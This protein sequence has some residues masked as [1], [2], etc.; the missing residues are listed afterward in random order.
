VTGGDP[1]RTWSLS[2]PAVFLRAACVGRWEL[3]DPAG[4][5]ETPDA[6]AER[7]AAAQRLCTRCTCLTPCRELTA[8]IPAS[9]RAGVWAGQVHTPDRTTTSTHRPMRTPQ[10]THRG[11]HPMPTPYIPRRRELDYPRLDARDRPAADELAEQRRAAGPHRS[12][13]AK[14][15]PTTPTE[16]TK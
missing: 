10:R 12:S 4:E 6:V 7:H 16:G 3:F 2:N 9:A 1:T 5:R 15:R 11:D 13:R 8:T 14:P